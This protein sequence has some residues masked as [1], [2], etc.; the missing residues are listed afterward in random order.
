MTASA[1]RQQ[2]ALYIAEAISWNDDRSGLMQIE[3]NACRC[4]RQ[5][6]AGMKNPIL[7][8]ASKRKQ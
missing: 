1:A 4:D 3:F 5:A 6:T 7:G 2:A 8:K